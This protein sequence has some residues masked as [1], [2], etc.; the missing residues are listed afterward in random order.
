MKS[1]VTMIQR[2]MD[3]FAVFIRGARCEVKVRQAVVRHGVELSGTAADD[4]QGQAGVE[5]GAGS[6]NR[7]AVKRGKKE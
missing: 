7:P 6:R 2:Q 1:S 5:E 4:G 3:P